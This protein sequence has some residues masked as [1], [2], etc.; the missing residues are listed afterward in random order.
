[1]ERGKSCHVQQVAYRFPRQVDLFHIVRGDRLLRVPLVQNAF[2]SADVVYDKVEHLLNKDGVGP[3]VAKGGWD[4]PV[5]PLHE[6]D[7]RQ[8]HPHYA[9]FV[10]EGWRNN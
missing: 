5:L 7:R 6:R 10:R 3:G 1:M 2:D 4:Q 8:G 9:A